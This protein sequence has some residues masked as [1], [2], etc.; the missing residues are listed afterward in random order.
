MKAILFFKV[1]ERKVSFPNQTQVK[2][3]QI[4]FIISDI[5]TS[6]SPSTQNYAINWCHCNKSI[7]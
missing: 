7:F 4:I 2:V 3:G 5:F 6:P 1:T